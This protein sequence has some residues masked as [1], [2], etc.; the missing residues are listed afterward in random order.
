MREKDV[1][2]TAK[3]RIGEEIITRLEEFAKVLESGEPLDKHY[4]ITT[5]ERV[6]RFENVITTRGPGRERKTKEKGEKEGG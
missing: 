1:G 5:I 6:N 3:K 2:K 4:N